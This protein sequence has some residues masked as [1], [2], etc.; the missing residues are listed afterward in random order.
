MHSPLV[1]AY[2]AAFVARCDAMWTPGCAMVNEPG[3]YGLLSTIEDPPTR[4]MVTDDGAYDALADL[5][6][7]AGG[8]IVSVFV[9]AV[10]C[11]ALVAE[12]A[13]WPPK[14]VTAMICRDRWTGPNAPLPRGLALRPVRRRDEDPEDGVPLDDAVAAATGADNPGQDAPKALAAFLRT[15]PPTM[16]LFAAID[17]DGVVRATSGSGTFGEQASV[18]FVN[19]DPDWR[20]LGIGQAMTAAAL[21]AARDA[22]ARQ[23]C[24]DATDAAIGV[25]LRLG[26]EKVAPTTQFYRA[27]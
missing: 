19:T 8:G 1:D 17:D 7:D 26:F 3:V 13:R 21:N 22:G 10:R 23:A 18:I 6:R 24:L 5:L 2:V 14:R 25:Y 4:L 11:T 20:R 12:S 16:R 27:R 9:E 15:L